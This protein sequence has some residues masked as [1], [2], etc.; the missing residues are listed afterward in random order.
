MTKLKRDKW[1]QYR[2][3]RTIPALAARIPETRLLKLNMMTKLLPQYQGI[4]LKPRGG[5]FGRHILFITLNRSRSYRVHVEKK[6]FTFKKTKPLIQWISKMTGSRS[7]IVQR[8]LWLARIRGN[9]FDIRIMVQRRKGASSTWN[10]TGSYAKI[11][12]Q[13]YLVTNVPSGILPVS[14]ALK[15]ARIG[16]RS[17]LVQCERIARLAARRL[18]ERFPKLRQVGFDLGIDEKRRIWI[19]EGNYKPDLLPFRLLKDSS[20]YRRIRWYQNH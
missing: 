6:T 17:L 18:G 5:R 14:E 15:H 16:D 19:L 13:G 10:V 11:A 9:P 7:Y 3:L 20:I 12:A 2:I 1:L 4:V 8:R